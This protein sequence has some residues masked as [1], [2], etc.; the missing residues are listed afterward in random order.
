MMRAADYSDTWFMTA[1]G[2]MKVYY[3]C[4]ANIPKCWT[5]ILSKKW[6]MLHDDPWA[7]GQRWYC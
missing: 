7:M 4:K 1:R 3:V 5:L 6:D 2:G